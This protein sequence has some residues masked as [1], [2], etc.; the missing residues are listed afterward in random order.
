MQDF[1]NERVRQSV[2]YLRAMGY[3]TNSKDLAEKMHRSRSALSEIMSGARPVSEKFLYELLRMFPELNKSFFIDETCDQMLVDGAEGQK[4][5]QAIAGAVVGSVQNKPNTA[6][7]NAELKALVE[8]Y[9]ATIKYLQEHIKQLSDII[10]K[11]TS[12]R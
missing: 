3:I 10:L 1:K 7:S 8:N 6:E 11:L 9:A 4:I 12:N 5:A 2:N